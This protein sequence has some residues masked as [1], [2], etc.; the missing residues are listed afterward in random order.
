[1]QKSPGKRHV[2]SPKRKLYDLVYYLRHKEKVNRASLEYIKNTPDYQIYAKLYSRWRY[3]LANGS[4]TVPFNAP[5]RETRIEMLKRKEAGCV[6]CQSKE[7]LQLDHADRNVNNNSL[8]N[9]RWMCRKC[10]HD[11]TNRGKL[12]DIRKGD[13]Y[14]KIKEL[15]HKKPFSS[16]EDVDSQN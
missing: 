13:A 8:A 14:Q 15:V 1:M 3:A 6:M 10:H 9:L 16:Y 5:F 2:G 11:E 4:T 12:D 7:T